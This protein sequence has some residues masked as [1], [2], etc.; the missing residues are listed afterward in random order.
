[1][2]I[3]VYQNYCPEF[4]LSILCKVQ[5]SERHFLIQAKIQ[6]K[7]SASERS[8]FLKVCDL[9]SENYYCIK[10]ES[11][12]HDPVLSPDSCS[13]TDQSE[14][15]RKNE[16][17]PCFWTFEDTFMGSCVKYSRVGVKNIYDN[18]FKVNQWN[19]WMK[20]HPKINETAPQFSELVLHNLKEPTNFYEVQRFFRNETK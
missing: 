17:L 11:V 13:K 4:L 10:L 18:L 1:M 14:A 2:P 19:N 20:D 15:A 16:S 12:K 3:K 6:L 9:V 7:N 5:N 8:F